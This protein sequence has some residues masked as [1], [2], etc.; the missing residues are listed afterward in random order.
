[1]L[2]TSESILPL[3][4]KYITTCGEGSA[5]TVFK[6]Y[7]IVTEETRALK[8]LKGISVPD[9]ELFA[10][11]FRILSQLHHPNLVQV[12]DF[13]TLVDGSLYFTMDYVDGVPINDVCKNYSLQQRL[14]I[15]SKVCIPVLNAI[16][17]VHAAGR[18]HG[19]IKPSNILIDTGNDGHVHVVDFGIAAL[20]GNNDGI[21]GTLE[22]LAPEVLQGWRLGIHTD[23]YSLGVLFY[24]LLTG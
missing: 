8:T 10:A 4:Y 5:G 18:I 19:D 7:D 24:E 21:S 1:M 9:K 12:H 11:E 2:T 13:G 3:R 20:Q 6:V 22:Y 17:Y 15:F 23:I 14:E 16:E